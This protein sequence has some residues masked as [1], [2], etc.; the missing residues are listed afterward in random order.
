[1]NMDVNFFLCIVHM[2][3]S[4]DRTSKGIPISTTITTGKNHDAIILEKSID[5]IAVDH[6]SKKFVLDDTGFF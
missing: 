6:V 2:T 5:D 4:K 3:H 1:M